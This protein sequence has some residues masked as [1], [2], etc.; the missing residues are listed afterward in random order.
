[1][2]DRKSQSFFRKMDT[3]LL[4]ERNFGVIW[5]MM[6]L[7]F[8]EYN[9]S[10]VELDRLFKKFHPQVLE[11]RLP[12]TFARARTLVKSTDFGSKY[13][14]CHVAEPEHEIP[15]NVMHYAYKQI[16]DHKPTRTQPPSTI[17]KIDRPVKKRNKC[18]DQPKKK[19]KVSTDQPLVSDLLNVCT[20]V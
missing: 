12:V 18:D 14:A 9:L 2:D 20:D 6:V 4:L 8:K 13:N 7:E 17:A 10:D 5:D 16:H 1:M 11:E 3:D 19:V 15:F